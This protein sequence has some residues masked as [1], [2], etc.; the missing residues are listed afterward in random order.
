VRIEAQ[1]YPA[2]QEPKSVLA[3]SIRIDRASVWRSAPLRRGLITLAAIPGGAAALAGLPWHLL[4]LLPGLAASGAGLLFGVN[5]LA[6]DGSGAVWREGL[7]GVPR[8]LLVA[9]LIVVAEVCVLAGAE[10]A[11]IGTLRASARPTSAEVI[12]VAGSLIASTALVVGRC[13]RWSL[14]HPYAAKLRDARDHPA[15]HTAMAGYS[16]RLALTTTF[17][18]LVFSLCARLQLTGAA[19]LFTLAA[20]L[21]CAM[22]VSGVLDRW[23]DHRR[24]SQVIATVAA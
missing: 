8:T 4:V 18:G 21:W 6:L 1:R 22:T 20:G 7:P 9:R 24:R 12:A 15:P 5:A 16:A 13:A 3:L 2:R 17:T 23:D 14:A 11:A 19:V 10:A